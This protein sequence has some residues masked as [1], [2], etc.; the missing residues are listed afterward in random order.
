MKVVELTN[1]VLAKMSQ[2]GIKGLMDNSQQKKMDR[3][4]YAATLI[5]FLHVLLSIWL[6]KTL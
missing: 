1:D 3:E 5:P 6:I 4:L 2:L